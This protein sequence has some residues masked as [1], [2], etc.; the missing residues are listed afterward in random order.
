ME[1]GI[2]S[3]GGVWFE[4]MDQEAQ[5]NDKSLTVRGSAFQLCSKVHPQWPRALGIYIYFINKSLWPMYLNLWN[6]K[7]LTWFNRKRLFAIMLTETWNLRKGPDIILT[8]NFI[9]PV[10]TVNNRLFQDVNGRYITKK[11][12]FCTIPVIHTR[13]SL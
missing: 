4:V 5:P 1:Q 10:N 13:K 9:Q 11:R 3:W 6:R 8:R 12:E 2:P 7:F